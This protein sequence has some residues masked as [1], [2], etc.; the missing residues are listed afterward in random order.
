MAEEQLVFVVGDLFLAGVD[1]TFNAMAFT[2]VYMVCN[3]EVQK[4]VQAEIDAVV[5]W[6]RLPGLIDRPK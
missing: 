2:L 5:G 6:D 1:T 3:P 4:K